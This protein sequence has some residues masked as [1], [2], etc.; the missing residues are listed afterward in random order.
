MNRK[1]NPI[2]VV[3]NYA[4]HIE[5]HMRG[6]PHAHIVLWFTNGPSIRD[7]SSSDLFDAA[8]WYGGR[9]NCSLP[10][11]PTLRTLVSRFQ[12]HAHSR[13][14]KKRR[15]VCKLGFPRLPS[16]MDIIAEPLD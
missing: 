10:N 14:C 2:G 12:T 1:L 6:S 13:T 16:D 5:F 4:I 11:E 15:N 7:C 3:E 9:M 8:N